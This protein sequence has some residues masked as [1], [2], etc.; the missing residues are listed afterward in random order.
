MMTMILLC[1][2]L[3]LIVF[4]LPLVWVVCYLTRYRARNGSV[5]QEYYV[6]RKKRIRL[7]W[8]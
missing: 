5:G 1:E 3:Q 4:T 8:R 7:V 2:L 6:R